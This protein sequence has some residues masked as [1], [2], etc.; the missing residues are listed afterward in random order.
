MKKLSSIES[1]VVNILSEECAEVIQII[2]KIQRFGLDSCHPNEPNVTNLDNLH[3]E[4]G[5]LLAMVGICINIKL[6][7]EE[8]LALAVD[9]KVEKLKKWSTIFKD[10]EA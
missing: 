5:D 9:R 8:K 1:E 2:S 10:E 6:I 3:S 4:L 7:E